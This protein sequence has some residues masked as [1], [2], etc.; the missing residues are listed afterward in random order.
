MARPR[1]RRAVDDVGEVDEVEW[2]EDGELVAVLAR[3]LAAAEQLLTAA[4]ADLTAE[5]VRTITLVAVA[6]LAERRGG[7]PEGGHPGGGVRYAVR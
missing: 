2:A 7:S 5:F 1:P 6:R 3:E 4:Q